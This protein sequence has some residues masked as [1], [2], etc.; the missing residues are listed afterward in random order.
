MGA[1]GPLGSHGPLGVGGENG[2]FPWAPLGGLVAVGPLGPLGP[3]ALGSRWYVT[4]GTPGIPRVYIQAPM[5]LRRGDPL[6]TLNT[7]LRS[8]HHIQ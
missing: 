6:G 1:H 8:A 2:P 5:G 7:S 3:W 4:P